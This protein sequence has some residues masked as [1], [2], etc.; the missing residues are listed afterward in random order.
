MPGDINV[1]SSRVSR[2][3]V[4][5]AIVLAFMHSPYSKLGRPALKDILETNWDK[6]SV[7]DALKLQPILDALKAEPA[8]KLETVVPPLARIKTWEAFLKLRVEM[9]RELM[10]KGIIDVS[11]AERFAAEC[12]VPENLLVRALPGAASVK[13]EGSRTSVTVHRPDAEEGSGKKLVA[14]LLVAMV[15]AGGAGG[16]MWWRVRHTAVPVDINAVSEHIP[17]ST[18]TRQGNEVVAT[19]ANRMWLEAFPKDARIT[20]VTA[21]FERVRKLDGVTS[22]KLV[23]SNGTVLAEAALGKGTAP[24]VQVHR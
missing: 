6:I 11:S 5:E 15:L 7:G 3:S 12:R 21:A 24:T 1:E 9:P 13:R 14:G 23:D 16:F 17:L 20:Q 2:E 10:G 22:F 8:F 4:M 18:A 19:L